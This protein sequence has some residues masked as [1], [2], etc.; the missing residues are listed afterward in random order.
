MFSHCKT[1]EELKKAY[2]RE[3]LKHPPDRGGSADA[4]LNVSRQ[5]AKRRRELDEPT[6]KPIID[7]PPE[8]AARVTKISEKLIDDALSEVK[9]K[10]MGSIL[11]LIVK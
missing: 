6:K 8:M 9:K 10:V 4:F 1:H 3:S 7:L 2:R 5:M 11:K